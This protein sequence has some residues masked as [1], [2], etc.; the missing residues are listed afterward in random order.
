LADALEMENLTEAHFIVLFVTTLTKTSAT[1]F[2]IAMSGLLTCDL[3]YNMM[4][5]FLTEEAQCLIPATEVKSIHKVHR[6]VAGLYQ[7]LLGGRDCIPY[8]VAGD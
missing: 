8:L 6:V 3:D 5:C 1:I 2:V 4:V 7:E